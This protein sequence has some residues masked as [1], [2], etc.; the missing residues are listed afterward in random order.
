[1]GESEIMIPCFDFRR[2][3]GFGIEEGGEAWR[4]MGDKVREACENHGCFLIISDEISSV[5]RDQMFMGMKTLFNLPQE[6]KQKHTSS[7]P[8][9]SYNGKSPITPFFESFGI[10][11]APLPNIAQEFTNLMWPHGNL[12][13]C[14]ADAE[15][16]KSTSYLR[17][18]KYHVPEERNYE[19]EI[20]LVA[21][22]DKNALTIL[23]ENE[24]QALQVQ[25]KTGKWID[26]KIPQQGF[27]VIVGDVLKAWSN[28][29]L[30]AAT[31]RVVIGD[32]E[33]ERYSLGLFA[34]PKDEMKVKVP[35]E[36]IDEK[37]HPLRYKP[38]N[39]GEYIHYYVSTL[40][41]DALEVFANDCNTESIEE[42]LRSVGCPN[43][44]R[45]SHV[46]D[47]DTEAIFP[48]I[49]WLVQRVS[50][51]QEYRHNK[52]SHSDY[53][54][55]EGEYKP[56]QFKEVEKTESSIKTLRGNLDELNHR[57]MNVVKQLEHLRERINKEGADSGV[58]KLI[59]LMTSLKVIYNVNTHTD[60][61]Y[62]TL[63]L[64]IKKLPL[65][66]KLER[67]ENH[68][69]SNC[70]S[71]HS[72]LQAEISEL[73]RK[74]ANGWDSKSLSDG[75]HC[76][77]SD[78][79]ERLDLTK[80]Q[81]ASKLRDIV[82]LRRQIDDLPCQSEIIQ[83]SFIFANV[84]GKHQQTHKYYATYN[85][86]LEIKELM[87]KEASLLNSII[88]QFQEALSS[89]DGRAKLVHSMEGI[90]KGSQQKLEKVQLAFREEEKNLTDFKDKYAAAAGQHKRLYSLLKAFQASFFFIQCMAAFTKFLFVQYLCASSAL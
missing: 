20:T 44:L 49:Q 57:K 10:D 35:Y 71:K 6:I 23:C 55:G 61:E 73:K 79:L 68:F 7:R 84:Q 74:I 85:A 34:S 69:Q 48:V 37:T 88:S 26:I 45:S 4:E 58:Q 17:L 12:L 89:T 46:R 78:L 42:A 31:H 5:L 16:M 32:E 41:H 30:H 82:A 43:P 1:M 25:T 50:S 62:F 70:D 72:E 14:H 54:F 38:F 3:D 77:F 75:L 81:L 83:I 40:K 90:V 39:Y 66:Q 53:T 29:R 22:T 60:S 19:S 76:S 9:R 21:H 27:L 15:N 51:T 2:V 28:G 47:L 59:Y 56:Q 11:D 63:V 87:L 33:K 36:L 80:K 13:Y 8:Y 67:Q 86:L 24:V 18:I 52:V 64:S 65:V